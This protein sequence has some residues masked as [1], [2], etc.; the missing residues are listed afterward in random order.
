MQT[1]VQL[2]TRILHVQ[3]GV[4]KH[5]E[6]E[7]KDNLIARLL[8]K[9][10]RLMESKESASLL[11]LQV[12]ATSMKNKKNDESRN[13]TNIPALKKG[14]TA[15]D[16]VRKVIGYVSVQTKKNRKADQ[17]KESLTYVCEVKALWTKRTKQ[18]EDI[19]LADSASLI[20]VTFR[21]DF[22]TFLKSLKKK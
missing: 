14:K 17:K 15:K 3:N 9:D 16:A 18:D 7:T 4:G 22:I 20:H 12:N 2:D 19:L 11:A 13:K 6:R 10:K 21:R 8:R 1:I 5:F